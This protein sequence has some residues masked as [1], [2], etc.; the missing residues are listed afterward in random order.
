M[1]GVWLEPI[2]SMLRRKTNES[3]TDRHRNALRKLVVWKEDRLRRGST[4][5]TR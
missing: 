2:Q 4:T 3:W 5:V 1:K